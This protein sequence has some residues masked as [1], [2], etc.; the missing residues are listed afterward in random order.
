M[1]LVPTPIL[2]SETVVFGQQEVELFE[3]SAYHRCEYLQKTT[4]DIPLPQ[5]E[6]LPETELENFGQLWAFRAGEVSKKLLLVAY[7]IWMKPDCQA[8]LEQIHQGLIRSVTPKLIDQL[9]IPAAKLSGLFVDVQ[10]EKADSETES[11]EAEKK[12]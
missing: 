12:G 11:E 3:L 7:A 5:D 6:E 8:S 10:T 1:N 9:Y 2:E 4:E